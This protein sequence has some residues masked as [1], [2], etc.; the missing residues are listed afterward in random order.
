MASITNS[1]QNV[2]NH[3]LLQS[4]TTQSADIDAKHLQTSEDYVILKQNTHLCHKYNNNQNKYD[5]L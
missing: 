1:L 4:Q 3:V 2:I 5:N